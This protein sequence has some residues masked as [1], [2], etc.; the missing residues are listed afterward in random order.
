VKNKQGG[1]PELDGGAV[2]LSGHHTQGESEPAQAI[3]CAIGVT[4]REASRR[5]ALPLPAGEG[6]SDGQRLEGTPLLERPDEAGGEI[7]LERRLAEG[8]CGPLLDLQAAGEGAQARLHEP[9]PDALKIIG[10]GGGEERA[11]GRLR[12]PCQDGLGG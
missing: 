12:S 5:V 7:V 11:G 2:L 4:N 1:Q 9:L 10:A 3:R 8:S 6:E